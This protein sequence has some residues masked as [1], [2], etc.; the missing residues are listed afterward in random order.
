[1]MT[2]D[3][4]RLRPVMVPVAADALHELEHFGREMQAAQAE[5]AG[6]MR[7]AFGKAR[8]TA[9]R[10]ALVLELLWWCGR[11]DMSSPPIT[12]SRRAFVAAAY[13]VADYLMPMGERVYGDA[14]MP[15]VERNGCTL[16]RWIY[17]SRPREVH[18]PT[19][20]RQVQATGPPR[21]Q[22]DP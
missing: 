8:G 5:A 12:I 11:D 15:Q 2:G 21:G 9:L 3:D 18:V 4:G 13:L 19:L 1:M 14:A 20:Q 6:L 17:R 16:A 22:R 10:L 7:S